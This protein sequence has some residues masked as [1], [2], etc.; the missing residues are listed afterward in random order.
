MLYSIYLTCFAHVLTLYFTS[1][2]LYRA[3]KFQ[4]FTRKL[5]RWGFRQVNRGIGPD[6]PIIFGNEH[7]QR[8][9]E[10]LMVKMRSTTAAS[11]RRARGDM[12]S[13]AGR[14]RSLEELDEQRKAILL[15]R[16]MAEKAAM[17]GDPR[18]IANYGMTAF[19]PGVNP[20]YMPPMMMQRY[21]P[22]GMYMHHM[23]PL[24]GVE[25]EAKEAP[26]TPGQE[27]GDESKPAPSPKNEQDIIE[28]AK[29][30]LET[31]I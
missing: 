26:P 9:D 21:G 15:E 8:D 18:F 30:A 28:S 3:T 16:L 20:G 24:Q 31:A 19:P 27:G 22:P 10:E 1:F 14:K 6:D 23:Q 12:S 25:G 29:A 11:N 5:Y 4:S 7:F 2:L 13:L 17:G